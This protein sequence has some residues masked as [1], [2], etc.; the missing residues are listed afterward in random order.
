M[1]KIEWRKYRKTF[2][3]VIFLIR[4]NFFEISAQNFRHHF[5]LCHWFG[6]FP[7]VFQSSII[8]NYDVY[9]ALVLH[10]YCTALGQSESSNF[11]CIVL[12]LL[13]FTQLKNFILVIPW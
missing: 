12:K 4:E 2:L 13:F 7:I 5:M 11:S 3:E 1:K 10:F 9:F 6:K 8:Q